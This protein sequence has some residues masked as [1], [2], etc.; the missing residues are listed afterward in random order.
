MCDVHM[1]DKSMESRHPYI[2]TAH[3]FEINDIKFSMDSNTSVAI[4]APDGD[5]WNT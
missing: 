3:N 5:M 4:L 1:T 2:T